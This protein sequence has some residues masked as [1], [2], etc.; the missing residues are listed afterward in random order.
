MKIALFAPS[1]PPGASAN[2]IVTYASQLVPTL[3][4][5]GHQVFVLTFDK[6]IDDKDT[7]TIDL[8]KFAS[9]PSLWDRAARR[10]APARASFKAVSSALVAAICELGKQG[11]DVFE[12]EES[13]G[14]SYAVSRLNVVPVVV[15]LHGPWF[16]TG[17]FGDPG[18][19]LANNYDREQRERTGIEYAHFVSSPSAAVLQA[20]R[21][22][23][24]LKLS[25]S[26]LIPHPIEAVADA[27][28]WNIETCSSNNLLYVGRF[29]RRKGGDLV[30]RAFAELAASY[31]NLILKFVGPDIGI[32]GADDTILSFEEYVGHHIPEQYRSRIEF[33]GLMRHSDIMS[34]RTKCF[35]TVIASQ[36]ENVPYSVLEAMSVGC[37][38]VATAVG[39]IPE[40]IKDQHNGLLVPS[41]DEKALTAAC[42]KL[43]DERALATRLG[44]QARVDCR[45][46]YGPENIARQTIATYQEVVKTFRI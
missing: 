19:A 42:R 33:C 37:P 9:S 32:K 1:W 12:I 26:R 25:E 11:L 3:R 45:N 29:D 36:Y 23:Y 22:H 8:R 20:V 27:D 24:G 2:G 40:M 43:I 5:L 18:D 30:L 21:D 16:L 28:A 34:L 39:G 35:A 10:L 6:R 17:R 44:K 14:W 41:Q 13:F 46:L 7:Y 4:R 31:P 15:M 38:L